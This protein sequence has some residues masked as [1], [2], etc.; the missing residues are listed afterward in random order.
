MKVGDRIKLTNPDFHGHRVNDEGV[1]VFKHWSDAYC[2]MFGVI[3]DK[4]RDPCV[5]PDEGWSYSNLEMEL[6]NDPA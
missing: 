6:I 4:R 5:A 2:E 1:I 3:L